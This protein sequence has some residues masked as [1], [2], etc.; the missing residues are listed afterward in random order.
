MKLEP[1]A[2]YAL[3]RVD[4]FKERYGKGIDCYTELK[5]AYNLRDEELEYIVRHEETDE[6]EIEKIL[7]YLTKKVSGSSL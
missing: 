5:Y 1:T 7:N 4:L 6:Y 3:S 2:K